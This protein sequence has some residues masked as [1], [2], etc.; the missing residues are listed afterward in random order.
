[1]VSTAACTQLSNLSTETAGQDQTNTTIPYWACTG[2]QQ[3]LRLRPALSLD[4]TAA[5]KQRALGE[6]ADRT[7]T[8]VR[9]NVD[10]LWQRAFDPA[11]G[12]AII[13]T[14]YNTADV[15]IKR[16]GAD[17][18]CTS[19]SG[20]F[21]A[22]PPLVGRYAG[23]EID[24]TRI[25]EDFTLTPSDARL[26]AI[27]THVIGDN[28]KGIGASDA[29]YRAVCLDSSAPTRRNLGNLTQPPLWQRCSASQRE[30]ASLH[31]LNIGSQDIDL[32]VSVNGFDL[33]P[34]GVK[35]DGQRGCTSIAHN[36][37]D[38][39]VDID[40][41]AGQAGQP[42]EHVDIAA[43]VKASAGVIDT[44]QF[45]T[46]IYNYCVEENNLSVNGARF[47][48]Y[49]NIYPGHPLLPPDYEPGV[50]PL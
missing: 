33:C 11:E 21:D 38:G 43:V 36:T 50:I 17:I 35:G 12:I 3:T 9:T 44:D 40:F 14:Q 22:P 10:I 23:F 7:S 16:E 46:V 18:S 6:V 30:G 13:D 48:T 24:T 15:T 29:T 26:Q 19:V 32:A 5:F 4:C 1:M 2:D 39:Y 41:I 31:I 34:L 37:A 20:D 42:I 47:G 25:A 27:A 45:S 28:A 8:V 49:N